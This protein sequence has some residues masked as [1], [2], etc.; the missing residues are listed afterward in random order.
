M[1]DN[2][3]EGN[4]LRITRFQENGNWVEKER[5]LT[6]PGDA[7]RDRQYLDWILAEKSDESTLNDDF[8]DLMIKQH[9]LATKF[10]KIGA[11]DVLAARDIVSLPQDTD[12]VIEAQIKTNDPAV[13]STLTRISQI[14]GAEYLKNLSDT[15][16][17]ALYKVHSISGK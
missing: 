17:Y 15:E 3:T 1:G 10:G 13:E 16:I 14:Y 6:L 2:G 9:D 5:A 11:F 4:V 8:N 7:F 12:A